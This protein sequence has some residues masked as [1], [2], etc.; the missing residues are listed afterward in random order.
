MKMKKIYISILIIIENPFK[1]GYMVLKHAITK[2]H[3][4]ICVSCREG[5]IIKSFKER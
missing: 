4:V 3:I 1:R 2:Y 5:S